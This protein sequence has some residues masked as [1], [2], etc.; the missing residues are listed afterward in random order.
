MTEQP[1][2]P[3]KGTGNRRWITFGFVL[4]T[5]VVVLIAG[6]VLTVGGG[7]GDDD[8]SSPT[9]TG[10]IRGRAVV[11]M[12]LAPPVPS[13]VST[14]VQNVL[15][16]RLTAADITSTI[17]L[18]SAEQFSIDF[19][20]Q[21]S[22][23]F[24][25][26]LLVTPGV[27][28][29]EPVLD[30]TAI[31]CKDTSGNEFSIEPELLQLSGNLPLCVSADNRNGEVEWQPAT[32]PINGVDRELTGA[33]ITG[34]AQSTSDGGAPVINAGF[35]DEGKTILQEVTKDLVGY[36]LGVFL[37][38]S[39]LMA[40]KIQREIQNGRIVLA[41]ASLDVMQELNAVIKGGELPITISLV[42]IEQQ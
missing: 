40:P 4:A 39:L 34:V 32:G 42:S 2:T 18:A 33:L 24:I 11:H 1:P 36:P 27:R 31:K 22:V 30:G 17:T 38:D 35:S 19:D 21:H 12:D 6:V 5:V 41:G 37:G 20:G 23:N 3:P 28:F 10:G 9:P 14:A 8:A 29:K 13:D 15:K 26:D 25:T 16:N 7:S